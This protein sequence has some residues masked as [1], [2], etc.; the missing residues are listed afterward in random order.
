M[1]LL[2]M[3]AILQQVNANPGLKV[4]QRIIFF[5]PENVFHCLNVLCSLRLFKLG[6]EG[7]TNRK[8]HLKVTELQVLH[9]VEHVTA[10]LLPTEQRW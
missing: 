9:K 1:Y 6:R 3:A 10:T 8:P 5:L 7:Q 4:N 2:N